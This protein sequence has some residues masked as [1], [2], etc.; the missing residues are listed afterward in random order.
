MLH[1][2]TIIEHRRVRYSQTIYS[3]GRPGSEKIVIC[4]PGLHCPGS[5]FV[6]E[7]DEFAGM[8]ENLCVINPVD[9]YAERQ[10]TGVLVNFF[11]R[12]PL[13]KIFAT[14]V[15]E[16]VQNYKTLI[17]EK[18]NKTKSPIILYGH[19]YGGHVMLTAL[20]E[21]LRESPE[22][23]PE[24]QQRVKLICDRTFEAVDYVYPYL[25]RLFT[26]WVLQQFAFLA[27]VSPSRMAQHLW[28]EKIA[29]LVMHTQA[30]EQVDYSHSL[31]QACLQDKRVTDKSLIVVFEHGWHFSS[32]DGIYNGA[33]GTMRRFLDMTAYVTGLEAELGRLSKIY[34][35]AQSKSPTRCFAD[36]RKDFFS[37]GR[38]SFANQRALQ[39][40]TETIPG[41]KTALLQRLVSG[42][43]SVV[44]YAFLWLL[45]G[46]D[47]LLS[48]ICWIFDCSFFHL[49]R[50][51]DGALFNRLNEDESTWSDIIFLVTGLPQW[52]CNFKVLSTIMPSTPNE[53]LVA[54]TAPGLLSRLVVYPLN[55]LIIL[56]AVI[57][58]AAVLL[59]TYLPY[60]FMDTVASL[61]SS[62]QKLASNNNS[63]QSEGDSE[64]ASR[65]PPQSSSRQPQPSV[66][67]RRNYGKFNFGEKSTLEKGSGTPSSDDVSLCKAGSKA[68]Y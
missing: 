38:V 39:S 28:H 24:I 14:Q 7:S 15:T 13:L 49:F 56:L 26:K 65:L 37:S 11:S 29:L 31:A 63:P 16:P 32:G 9:A 33:R 20:Y 4:A 57:T 25:P 60:A 8:Q 23:K 46:V 34:P 61:F 30:D 42:T 54:F 62:E 59:V 66:R 17:K 22:L 3:A 44:A 64:T 1:N 47:L 67:D 5:H 36:I 6:V 19:S 41:D 18:L 27:P 45:L 48:P 35:F 52:L 55:F 53:E 51:Q 12:V 50:H 68:P 58:T 10:Q 40:H 43:I 21:L 2:T